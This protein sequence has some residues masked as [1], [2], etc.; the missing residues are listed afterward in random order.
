MLN[1]RPGPNRHFRIVVSAWVLLIAGCT[2][3]P[4]VGPDYVRPQNPDF[5]AWQLGDPVYQPASSREQI[6]QWWHQLDD[7][8]L[9]WLIDQ[10]LASDLSVAAA[11]ARLRQ[12]RASRAV[13]VSAFYPTVSVTTAAT[14]T[15]YGASSSSRP[16][17][18]QFDVG[19]DA[20]W[21]LD[22][23]GATRRSVEASTAELQAAEAS[24]GNIQVTVVAEVAQ[25]YVD[26]RNFQQRLDIARRNLAAQA[27][28]LQI[29]QWRNQAG[30]VR[31]TDVDQA[32]ASLA[33]TRAGIPDLEIGLARAKNRLAVLTGQPPGAVN[34]RLAS[35]E[36]LP[37]LPDT[38]MT[39]VPA[40]VLTQR[41]D[42]QVAERHLAAQ[43]ALV[44][45]R[46]AERYPSLSLGGSFSW[47]AYSLTGLGTMDAFVSRVVGRL[48]ATIFDAGRL[49]SL[50]DVQTQAQQEALANYELA[51]LRALEEV[52]NALLAHALSRNRTQSWLEAAAASSS[53]A[54]QSRQ[55]YQA[56]LIDF[57]Q[58][59][60][61]ERAQLNAQESLAQSRAT[62]LIT[63]VQLYK[64]LGGG[65]QP[66][67]EPQTTQIQPEAD[68]QP[69]NKSESV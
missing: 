5:P 6:A 36:P 11:Q 59:L 52:E 10:A 29:A 40:T 4:S 14:P 54:T 28:T 44:G 56:G 7:A 15:N 60:I 26:V 18:T 22:I 53:A 34:E 38:I 32:R 51:V 3:L 12:A 66:E 25:N 62:E 13:A 49:R 67:H 21:E 35:R 47:S 17:Q 45:Q 58:V 24:L 61:T 55:L 65:W 43:T 20:S 9:D 16:D 64:A 39:D 1:L 30:L 69:Q 19:F 8:N 57:E 31:Q 37:I 68:Q 41:P 46:I 23:F 2:S 63:L 42:I 27:Q 33:Q 50:V 48:A